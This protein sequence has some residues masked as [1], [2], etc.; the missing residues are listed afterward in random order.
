[1]TPLFHP[2][3]HAC[4]RYTDRM[5]ARAFDAHHVDVRAFAKAAGTLEGAWPIGGFERLCESLALADGVHDA[6]SW[7]AHGRETMSGGG[8]RQVWLHLRASASLPLLCQRCLQPCRH[9]VSLDRQFQFVADERVAAELD[10]EAEHDV[11][12]IT[13]DL[14]LHALLEDEMLL[15]LPV[16]PRHDRCPHPLLVEAEVEV[17]EEPVQHPFA[18]LA[19]LRREKG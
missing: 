10:A 6:V 19:G 14:D 13:K 18:V 9:T 16:M 1:M 2:T 17:A 8:E 15:D 12:V 5:K 7:S 3:Q 4:R 11:L